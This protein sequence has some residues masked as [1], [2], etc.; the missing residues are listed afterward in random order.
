MILPRDEPERWVSFVAK[1]LQDDDHDVRSRAI[2]AANDYPGPTLIPFLH[3]VMLRDPD[4]TNAAEVVGR[5]AG[6]TAAAQAWINYLENS[7][8]GFV[9]TSNSLH[10]LFQVIGPLQAETIGPSNTKQMPPNSIPL[11]ND[12][13]PLSSAAAKPLKAALSDYRMRAGRSTCCRTVGGSR[14][15]MRKIGHLDA[16]ERGAFLG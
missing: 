3:A 1:A 11:L 5:I 8:V 15:R 12:Y 4:A 14:F 6:K 9:A 13:V 16:R 7:K 2:G 10:S